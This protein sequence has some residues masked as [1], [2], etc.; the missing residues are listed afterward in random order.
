MSNTQGK[1]S[2]PNVI[3]LDDLEKTEQDSVEDVLL[4]VC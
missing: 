1:T 2:I 3:D 4:Q